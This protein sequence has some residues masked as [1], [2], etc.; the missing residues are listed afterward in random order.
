MTTLDEYRPRMAT[1]LIVDDTPAN[2]GVVVDALGERGFRVLIALDGAE[3]I[4]RARFS[5]PDVILLDVNMP[6]DNGFETCRRL[7]A[8]EQTR[9]IPVIFMTVADA[10]SDMIEGFRAGGVDY[11][12]KPVRIDEIVARMNVH[13]TMREMQKALVEQ[14][15]QLQQEVSVRQQTERELSRVRDELELRVVRRT[16][17]LA[18]ANDDLR[19]EIA[20]R[21]RAQAQLKVSEARLREIVEASPVPLCIGALSTPRVLYANE[22]WRTLFGVC[23]SEQLHVDIDAFYVEEDGRHR[24]IE[25]VRAGNKVSDTEVQVKRLDGTTFWATI[26]ARLAT[27]QDEPAIYVGI[28]DVT[29]RKHIEQALLESQA[30]L[31]QLSAYMEAIREEER[32]RIA[33]EVH[34]ELG[35]LLTALKMEVSLLKMRLAGAPELL[36]KV[37][38]MRD[39]VEQTMLVVRNVAN[40]LRPAALNF[41]LVSAL[42]W[43]AEDFG[44]RTGIACHLLLN[45]GEPELSDAHATA[46]FRVM[47]ESMTNVARHARAT[48]VLVTMMRDDLGLVLNVSDN[49]CGFD[50]AAASKRGSYGLLG[51][52]ERARLIGASLQIDSAPG[53]GT[54]VSI[55]IP[56]ENGKEHDQDSDRG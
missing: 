7:K 17:Q 38:A 31:R 3:A 20:E 33:L 41:G 30:Q 35:Q 43:L 51:M 29:Q 25:R 44:K 12:T 5:Q 42:E 13:L 18:R 9:D 46:L 6:G 11:V 2:L 48:R 26:T 24:L 50:P 39:L 23:E 15:R 45:A 40:H 8:D 16:E 22:Q 19:A 4:A 52:S 32:K 56:V 34:D 10:M 47:Q 21:E 36:K 55:S 54:V 37:I 28:R 1:V 14:N 53:S 49:G 27:F